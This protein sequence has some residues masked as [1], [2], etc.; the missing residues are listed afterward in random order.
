VAGRDSLEVRALG[1]QLG[2]R[3]ILIVAAR[4]QPAAAGGLRITAFLVDAATGQ[5]RWV[6]EYSGALPLN[7]RSVAARIA[8]GLPRS[9]S[10]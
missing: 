10:R 2:V 3:E 6:E 7:S 8:A 1:E 9:M 5:K 4:P